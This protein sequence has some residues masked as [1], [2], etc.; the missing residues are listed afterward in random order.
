MAAEE[1][2][3]EKNDTQ[4]LLAFLNQSLLGQDE[5]VIDIVVFAGDKVLLSQSGE[6]DYTLGTQED[7]I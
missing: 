3:L 2:W 5:T 1:K 7:M 6:M 4:A